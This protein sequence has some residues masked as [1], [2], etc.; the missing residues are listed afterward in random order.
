[1]TITGALVLFSVTWFLTF[2]IVLQVRT[3]TQDEAGGEI[4]PARRAARPRWR[5][6]AKARRSPPFMPR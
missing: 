5:M 1:M 6:W 3:R 2:Y 4:V